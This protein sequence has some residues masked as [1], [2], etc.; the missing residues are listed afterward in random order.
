MKPLL[1]LLAATALAGCTTSNVK[2]QDD[3]IVTALTGK[4]ITFVTNRLGL[5]N[6][7]NELATGSMVWTYFDNEKGANAKA[8]RVSLSIRDG[9][10]ERVSIATENQSLVSFVSSSCSRIRSEVTRSS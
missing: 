2:P 1:T 8:C 6:R 5:P 10:V 7:R 3:A 9:V 4:P